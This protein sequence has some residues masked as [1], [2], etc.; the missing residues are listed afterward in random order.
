MGMILKPQ[1]VLVLLKLVAWN[2]ESWTYQELAESLGM[3]PSEVHAGMSR[4]FAARMVDAEKRRPLRPAFLEFLV[5]GLKY[6]FPPER[7]GQT[8][9]MPTG[10]ASPFAESKFSASDEP[11]PVWP[12]PQ[13]KRR[14][15][16]FSPLYAAAP[17]AARQDNA[18]YRLL[19]LVD[20][21]RGGNARERKWAEEELGKILGAD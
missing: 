12:H 4:A 18:L 15:L 10:H 13:G 6:A 5:H 20:M 8:R 2:R 11:P 1:D 14:G 7:G 9:G 16:A 3:S 19:V 17:E 21:I